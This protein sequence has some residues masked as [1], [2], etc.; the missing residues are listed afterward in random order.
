MNEDE[1][2]Q[3]QQKDSLVERGLRTGVRK[4]GN[5][6]LNVAKKGAK[7]VGSKLKIFIITHPHIALV[8]G[9][10][11]AVI[12][13]ALIAFAIWD[14][15]V[16]HS[17]ERIRAVTGESGLLE[18]VVKIEGREL[19]FAEDI[20]ELMNQYLISNGI[21]GESLGL[22]ENL[23]YFKKFIEAEVVT[24]FPD[25]RTRDQ[26]GTPIADNQLQ[27]I[28]QLKRNYEDGTSQ[29]MEYMPFD[30]YNEALKA[31][32]IDIKNRGSLVDFL[33]LGD[34]YIQRFQEYGIDTEERF[35]VEAEED[36]T[37]QEILALFQNTEDQINYTPKG[38]VLSVGFKDI[39][40]GEV[41]GQDGKISNIDT[42]KT[43][44]ETLVQ[45]YPNVPIYVQKILP[46]V[47]KP[48]Y[49]NTSKEN[50]EEYNRL[51]QE[52]CKANATKN[53]FFIN[54]IDG[55]IEENGYLKQ[56]VVDIDGHNIVRQYYRTWINNI[57]NKIIEVTTGLSTETSQQFKTKADAEREFNKIKTYFTLDEQFNLIVAK[58]SYTE[59][60]LNYSDYAKEE[61][62]SDEYEYHYRIDINT[63][64]YKT[65]VQKYIMPYEFPLALLVA[66][67][68]SEFA[69]AV[70][71]LARTGTIVISV[72]DNITTTNT[73][74]KYNYHSSTYVKKDITYRI[75]ETVSVKDE[76]GNDT[77]ATREVYRT[78]YAYPENRIDKDIQDYYTRTTINQMND[79]ELMITEA[80]TWLIDFTATYVHNPP[81]PIYTQ[82]KIDMG[83]DDGYR[84]V[85]D[86]HGY[87]ADLDSTLPSG[88]QI[89][90]SSGKKEEKQTNKTIDTSTMLAS[91]KYVRTKAEVVGRE[92]R[93]L[94][95]LKVDPNTGVFDK[96]DT[97][98][99]TK[100]VEYIVNPNSTITESPMG[101]L[102]G[103]T[104]WF[105]NVLSNNEKTQSY[106]ETARYLWYLLIG[107]DYGVTSL[108]FDI[109]LAEE[110]LDASFGLYTSADCSNIGLSAGVL[111][112]KARVEYYANIEGISDYVPVL[113]AIMM[114]ES[115]GNA[116]KT[117][118]VFQCSE[119]LGLKPNSIDTET[120][121]KQG[122]S[123]F[124]GALVKA[125]YDIDLALQ[126]YNFGHGF[127][128]YA[129]AR[130]G[131]SLENAKRFSK[132][133][134]K[135]GGDPEYVPH[136]KR[137]LEINQS[138]I[139]ITG[140]SSEKLR[141]LFPN[142]VPQTD[143]QMKPYLTT[144]TIEIL[145]KSGNVE[146]RNLKVH[147]AVAEDVKDI[148]AEIKNAGF[149][150]YSVG[151][152][153]W[154]SAAASTSRSHHSYGI[155]IDI[156][157]NENYMI[158][159]GKI[160]S[161]SFWKPSENEYSIAQN[162]AVVKA[163]TK[164]GWG[165]GGTWKSSKDYMHFSF[166]NK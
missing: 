34:S 159:G 41:I 84:N 128:P 70:A 93:F 5:K 129:I 131:Y 35:R 37:A 30:E 142:G 63:I 48:Y 42:Y 25:L 68:N 67:Q 58:M 12:L 120:S 161:G 73:V 147:K 50:I 100:Q 89:M 117:P 16:N 156:N 6:G 23:E 83:S 71:N 38:I 18:S 22:G 138:S 2:E 55:F 133:R 144:V 103:M 153:S 39:T 28:I 99:N 81:L 76:N 90:S 134:L 143:S 102:I 19:K 112:L 98:K 46:T 116:T 87:Y 115:G 111:A 124:K 97:S 130:G 11:L 157:P 155:A 78:R 160:I 66:S 85:E 92:E 136:V 114:Q 75:K 137:Y 24:S 36:Y 141:Q 154:R 86:Y 17:S 164:R 122:V 69:A 150:A 44:I 27:G 29:I 139:N 107:K 54:A 140:S 4:L 151:A 145:N 26:I 64:D 3:E 152:Y 118:D 13:V 31:L 15:S 8:V 52:Y 65:V 109:Y 108:D 74:E 56:S 94:S 110:F 60:T 45:K 101:N 91:N 88:A 121:I 163:F 148:F 7:I 79:M 113:L 47:E 126:G 123:Y 10:V 59:T 32:G 127:I 96:T 125:N 9:I 119:S 21:D 57:K 162:G 40:N 165:W 105:F 135:G 20:N 95:L 149:K 14:T 33:F 49:G 106:E 62:K 166:T 146:K 82:D 72:N 51:V 80:K 43:L 77:G 158:K 53:I 1:N 104:E 61:G 132:E